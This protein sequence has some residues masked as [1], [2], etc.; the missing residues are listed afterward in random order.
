M[1]SLYQSILLECAA[2]KSLTRGIAIF[3]VET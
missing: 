1:I 3:E 2:A